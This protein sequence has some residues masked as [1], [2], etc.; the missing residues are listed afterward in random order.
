MAK[1]G[2]DISKWNGTIDF[3]KV[4]NS[5]VE[6][7]IIREGY[8][9]K[10]PKQ[11]DKLFHRNIQE[12]QKVGLPVGVYHYSYA[13]S[14]Q[15]AILEAKFCLENIKRYKLEYPVVFDIEDKEQLKLNNQQRTN[16]C[17]AFCET[18]ENA[19]Y[20]AMIYC[21]I[22]WYRNYLI[23]DQLKGY[24]LWLA[25]W[26]VNAP[27]ES[28][29]IWQKSDKGTV[30]GIKGNVD[31][32]IAFRDY[33]TIMKTRGLNGFKINKKKTVD[34]IAREVINGL[35]GNNPERKNKLIAAGYNYEEVQKK[36]NE[37][38]K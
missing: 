27:F 25:Q 14:V 31:L 21:N 35:W 30:D 29:G 3:C 11:V 16:I 32:N 38:L 15:D 19:G 34:D 26:G 8:G 7:V 23:K 28:C 9:K 36:V 6:F 20:Y 37:L 2:I 33:P 18:I 10:D 17:R 13:D 5:G 24:D 12:A 1:N 22:N 4:K